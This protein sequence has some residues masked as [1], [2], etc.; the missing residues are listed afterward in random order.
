MSGIIKVSKLIMGIDESS[1]KIIPAAFSV[2]LVMVQLIIAVVESIKNL[3]ASIIIKEV[4][5]T[6]AAADFNILTQV[7]LAINEPTKFGLYNIF[8]IISSFMIL[9]FFVQQIQKAIA[10]FISNES[11]KNGLGTLIIAIL[12]L[13]IV[14][15]VAVISI[16]GKWVFPGIGIISLIINSPQIVSAFTSHLYNIKE[17]LITYV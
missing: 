10:F 14:E 5:K 16:F 9:I 8:I 6:I 12:F 11:V 2:V 15:V 4:A 3:D 1:K 7:Q 17:Y 13:S